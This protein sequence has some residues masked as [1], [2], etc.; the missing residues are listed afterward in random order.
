MK[1][2]IK[3]YEN[4]FKNPINTNLKD[5]ENFLQLIADLNVEIELFAIGGTAMVL[6]NI[7]EST[8]DIDFLTTANYDFLSNAFR[9][10][11]LKENDKSQLCNKWYLN[12]ETR[13]DIFYSEHI[14]GVTLPEDWKNLSEHIRNIG[15]LKLFILNWYDII[16]TKIARSEKRDIDDILKIIKTQ[17]INFNKLKR[18]Y[19]NLADTALISDYNL[20]FKHLEQKIQTEQFKK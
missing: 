8:K 20:K 9:L 19:Y 18:R 3:M 12:D 17:N 16:I 4:R 10:A 1:K 14:V 11:G 6:R 7:K 2:C 13:I 5:L 15:K